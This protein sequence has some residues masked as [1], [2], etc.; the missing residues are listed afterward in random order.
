M[1]KNQEKEKKKEIYLS[2]AELNLKKN[3][4]YK[5]FQKQEFQKRRE[6]QLKY[7]EFLNIQVFY[8]YIY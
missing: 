1:E 4:E 3:E 2:Q 6:E 7:R 5:E 8:N